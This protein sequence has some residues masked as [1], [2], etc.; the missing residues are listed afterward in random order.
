MSQK[1]KPQPEKL[2]SKIKHIVVLMLENRSFDNLL[3]WL[4]D[5]DKIPDNQSFEGLHNN[6]WNPLDN[7]D[8]EG[9][10]FIEKVPI[11]KNGQ[12]IIRREKEVPNPVDFTLPKPDPGE[13]YA[14]TNHQLF[15]KYKVGSLYPPKPINMGFVQNYNNAMLYGSYSFHDAPTDPRKIMSCYTPKQTKVL[16]SLAK[17]F[18]VCDQ[19]YASVPSQTLPNRAFVHAA[20]SDGNVNNAPNAFCHSKTIFNQIQDKIDDGNKDL[21]WGIF[22]NNPLSDKERDKSGNFGGNHFSLTRLAMTQL[23]DLKYDTNFH[24]LDKFFACCKKKGELPSY[25]FLEP[26]FSGADQ[27][28]Q[29][30]PQD[31][32]PGENLIANVYN[33]I[34]SS[35]SFE[36]TLLVI[37]YDEHGGC[38][39]HVAPPSS[40]K[41]PDPKNTP[42]QDGFRFNRFGIRVPCILVNPYIPKGLIAR[43]D[44][45]TPFDHT[46]VIKTIQNCFNLNEKLTERSE[47]APDF[48]CVLIR[49][50]PRG[51]TSL[52]KV[53]SH[54][55][56]TKSKHKL[57][58]E[59]I[60]LAYELNELHRLMALMVCEI[61][62]KPIPEDRK[63][64]HFTQEHYNVIFGKDRKH[65]FSYKKEIN[66]WEKSGHL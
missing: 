58:E 27:N 54:K 57:K 46:S 28:D 48:S 10:P 9:L 65:T 59:E 53:Q 66:K 7:I 19:Y 47:A 61:L 18:A 45:Y 25:S 16:S 55:L 56:K 49:N 12:K 29:H 11:A 14:D 15:L 64:L 20:T 24:S 37:T 44:G 35:P 23:H 43:P 41:N 5:E 33:A 21:S 17:N 40:A 30:P 36:E 4:Y 42:G 22:G 6:L 3:G 31:I 1:L 13:G 60:E 38:Y 39:D 52:P 26:V 50:T 8:S 32:R 62:D 2:Q 34:K 63:M 51:G